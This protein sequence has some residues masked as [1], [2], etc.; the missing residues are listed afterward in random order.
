MSKQR[1]RKSASKRFRITATGKVLHRASFGRHLKSAKSAAQ[2]R[3]YAKYSQILG[4]RAR[5]VKRMLAIA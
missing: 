3:R 4:R 5:R 1:T 2:K